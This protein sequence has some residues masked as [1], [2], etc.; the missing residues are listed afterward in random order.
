MPQYSVEVLDHLTAPK[1]SCL[2]TCGAVEIPPLPDFDAVLRMNQVLGGVR[3]KNRNAVVLIMMF[4]SR[5]KTAVSQYNQGRQF[6]EKYVNALPG[7]HLLEAH[8]NALAHFENSILQLHVAIV[9]LADISG[10]R[11][12]VYVSG[13]DYDRLRL[14]NNSIKHFDE[15]IEKAMK[16]ASSVPIAPVWITNDGLECTRTSLLFLDPT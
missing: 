6:L 2:T 8:R 4:I 10:M 12:K 16:R 3:Y 9:S 1:L 11:Q 15:H 7:N 5:L 14:L 13:S